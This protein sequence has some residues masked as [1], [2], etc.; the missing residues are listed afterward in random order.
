M[1]SR[2]KIGRG[3]YRGIYTEIARELGCTPQNVMRQVWD[4]N[5]AEMLKRVTAKIRERQAILDEFNQAT[6]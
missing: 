2:K 4:H 1:K 3:I 5:N 6:A